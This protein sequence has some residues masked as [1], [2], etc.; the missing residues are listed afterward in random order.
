MNY[1]EDL[2]AAQA[3]GLTDAY[4]QSL[5]PRDYPGTAGGAH[6]D[7]DCLARRPRVRCAHTFDLQRSAC[8]ACSGRPGAPCN[9]Y[10]PREVWI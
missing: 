4:E 6:W 3:A 10:T 1:A 8:R 5:I 9:D 2:H 7:D